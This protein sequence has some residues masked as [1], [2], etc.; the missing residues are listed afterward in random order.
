MNLPRHVSIACMFEGGME[1][2]SL[3]Y[4]SSG[5]EVSKRKP[6]AS[7]TERQASAQ[8]LGNPLPAHFEAAEVRIS[9]GPEQNGIKRP[10][11]FWGSFHSFRFARF[12]DPF[13]QR[14]RVRSSRYTVDDPLVPRPSTW[15][16]I[17][18]EEP[19]PMSRAPNTVAF[20]VFSTPSRVTLL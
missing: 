13:H 15:K 8:K 4:R 11:L 3:D 5:I 6:L 1:L 12:A 2:L 7:P 16:L 9:V 19:H 20:R 18:R 17:V 14:L 10:T